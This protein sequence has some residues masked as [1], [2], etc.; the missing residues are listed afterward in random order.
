[1][2]FAR[3]ATPAALPGLRPAAWLA[4]LLLALHATG[5]AA[6]P[7]QCDYSGF[8]KPCSAG[9]GEYRVLMPEGEGPFP[10]MIY[11]YGSGGRSVAVANHPLFEAAVAGRG[12]ALIVPAARHMDYAP[13]LRET[14]WALRA[15]ADR[16]GAQARD[17]AAFLRAVIDDAAR[18]FP[19]DRERILLAGQSR[20]GFLIWELACHEPELARAFAVHAAGYLGELPARCE[21][22]VRFLHSHGRADLIVPVEGRSP[23]P[24]FTGPSIQ[25]MSDSLDLLA[26]TNGCEGGAG[27]LVPYL[28]FQ[29]QSW[30][31]CGPGGQLD[32]MLHPGGHVMPP[33]WFRAVLDWFEEPVPEAEDRGPVVR[34]IGEGLPVTAATAAEASGEA[35]ADDAS[36]RRLAPGTRSESRFKAPPSP[37]EKALGRRTLKEL[38]LG[39]N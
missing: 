34:R 5:L 25:P 29:R 39:A 38:G 6:K 3:F 33:S 7:A 23:P 4:A 12:Y 16:A 18:R 24:G 9:D 15:E 8:E 26:E 17:E 30:R 11:L 32:L 14:G 27:D 37:G 20:G 28:D 35:N 2:P 10:A 1:M 36:P 22:P 31:D 13:G 19:V 21:R